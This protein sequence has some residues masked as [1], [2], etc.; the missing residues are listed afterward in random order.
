[1]DVAVEIES[2]ER[3]GWQ[4]LSGSDGAA[5]Y[6]DVMADDGV[7]VFP[8]SVLDRDA[9]LRAIVDARPWSTFDLA[10]MRVIEFGQGSVLVTYRATSQRE[11]EAEYRAVMS[12]VYGRRDGVWKL[13]L[14]QQSPERANG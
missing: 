7:M 3:R 14:H 8:G 9:S 1:M 12:S 6:A 11:G 10:D 5:F 13:V 2:L 4:A